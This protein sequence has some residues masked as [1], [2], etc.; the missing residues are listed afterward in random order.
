M[1][2]RWIVLLSLAL[3]LTLAGCASITAVEGERIVGGRM[4]VQAH[5]AWNQLT[6]PQDK[7]PFE[8]WT[9]HGFGLDQL[10]LW[11]GVRDGQPLLMPPAPAQGQKAARVPTFRAT[12]EHDQLANLFEVLYAADGSQVQITKMEATRFIG[13]RGVRLTFNVLRQRDD[14][15]LSGVVWMAVRQGELFAVAYTAPRLGFFSRGMPG[16]EAMVGSARVLGGR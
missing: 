5:P 14:V 4:A 2:P 15:Q 10:R 16:V 7:Q 6:A 1:R 3:T 12:M 13:E 11:G 9:Q 8:I